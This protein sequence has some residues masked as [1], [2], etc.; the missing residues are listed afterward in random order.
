MSIRAIVGEHGPNS[1]E[2]D[3]D[4]DS[5]STCA[6]WIFASVDS[7]GPRRR[8]PQADGSSQECRVELTIEEASLR[9]FEAKPQLEDA[10][11]F[12]ELALAGAVLP[13]VEP[14]TVEGS[15]PSLSIGDLT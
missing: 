3:A 14:P 4:V 11:P 10:D 1:R 5:N 2:L 7:R 9:G 12:G 15:T 13:R 6:C 8:Q